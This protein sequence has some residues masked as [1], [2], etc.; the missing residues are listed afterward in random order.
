MVRIV[1]RLHAIER[2]FERQISTEEVREVL[3]LGEVIEKYPDDTP[4]PSSLINGIVG[5]R[6]LHVVAAHSEIAEERIVITV[7]RP[8]PQQWDKE[9]RRRRP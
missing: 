5:G 2:M 8:D 4:Y 3:S 6:P 1:Y 9:F 7:Y